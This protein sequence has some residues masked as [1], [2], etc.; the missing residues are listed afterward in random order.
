MSSFAF[1]TARLQRT[2]DA[3]LPEVPT[4]L[5]DVL[6]PQLVTPV[7]SMSIA[8]FHT[9]PEQSRSVPGITVPANTLLFA[10]VEGSADR[11]TCRF[12]TGYPVALW[13]ITVDDARLES[14]SRH[15]FQDAYPR[16]QRVLR[17]RLRCQGNRRF[18]EMAPTSLRFYLPPPDGPR[19]EIY[20][21][22]FSHLQAIATAPIPFGSEPPDGP[23]ENPSLLP[24]TRLRAVGF[25]M[26]E[27]LLPTPQMSHQAYR[28]L[29]EYFTFTAKFLFFDVM[30]LQPGIFG[31]GT[32]AD[33]LFLLTSPRNHA[34]TVNAD[35]FKLGCTPIINHF[36][37]V[38]E[39]IRLDHMRLEYPLVADHRRPDSVEIHTLERVV[40]VAADTNQAR[41]IHPLFSHRRVEDND[42]GRILYHA[43]RRLPSD[44]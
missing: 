5:L 29:Q 32:H 8:A 28:I 13:P 14:V 42:G 12:R 18:N 19:M 17:I 37:R 16:V 7:P 27:A 2:Y 38:S 3:Q 23:G 25:G 34:A 35:S 20:E 26:D 30:D 41:T 21:M 33:L 36:P 39:P 43:R 40:G 15:P 9:D 10:N 6:Y 44:R 24:Q 11:L 1:L 31:D 4:A 22:L